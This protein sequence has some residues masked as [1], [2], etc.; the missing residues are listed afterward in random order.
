MWKRLILG[1]TIFIAI[2]AGSFY[3]LKAITGI[4]DDAPTA[5]ESI[6]PPRAPPKPT[7]T[8]DEP[9]PQPLPAPHPAPAVIQPKPKKL[10][11][12]HFNDEW[13]SDFKTWTDNYLPGHHFTTL[14]SQCYQESLLS[15]TA[16]SHVG[17]KGLCQFMD[18]TWDEVAPQLMFP[19]G[20]NAF[21]PELSIQAAAFYDAKLRRQWKTQRPEKDRMNLTFASYN[22]GL[23]NILKSQRAC[24]NATLYPAIIEC[25][26]LI[27]GRHSH[28]TKT[29]VTR[30]R[31]WEFQMRV[32]E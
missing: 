16:V 18:F 21:A 25:L 2:L 29:Y 23:G 15:P 22:A 11:Y 13:D 32:T 4:D 7:M 9:I 6:T 31:K 19:T 3:L 1:T 17:A 8:F 30:I 10:K 27:T 24:D 20:A 28:E 5:V 26:H 14:K 12:Q